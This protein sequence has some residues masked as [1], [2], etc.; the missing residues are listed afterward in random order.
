M[1]LAVTTDTSLQY[2]NGTDA[3]DTSEKARIPAYCDRIISKGD[4]LRQVGYDT[5]PLRFSDH[6]PVYATFECVVKV[7]DEA[8]KD[9]LTKEMYKLRRAQMSSALKTTQ[10]NGS[11]GE[12]LAAL[13]LST[14][15]STGASTERQRWWL[16][17]SI[18]HQ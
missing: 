9:A 3:Y 10:P 2:N 16:H 15:V 17:H 4:N 1:S 18:V 11:Q 14:P 5:A 12:N 8:K 6:R 13:A 7:E